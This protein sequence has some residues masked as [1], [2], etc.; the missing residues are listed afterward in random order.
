MTKGWKQKIAVCI[1]YAKGKTGSSNIFKEAG[2]EAVRY[3]TEEEEQQPK[4]LPEKSI[5]CSY[6]ERR[7]S[8]MTI[9]VNLIK[10]YL[11]YRK[12]GETIPRYF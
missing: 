5:Y 6:R 11:V 3:L 12:A 2:E 9:N 10:R 8:G 4:V 7:C 1:T